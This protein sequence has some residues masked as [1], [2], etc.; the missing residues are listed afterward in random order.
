MGHAGPGPEQ[1][2]SSSSSCLARCSCDWTHG[3][4]MDDTL[5]D[6]VNKVF[7]DSTTKGLIYRG[8]HGE[9]GPEVTDGTLRRGGVYKDEHSSL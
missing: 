8:L 6:G 1:A 7:V 5:S 2:A 3:L 9:L 4:H